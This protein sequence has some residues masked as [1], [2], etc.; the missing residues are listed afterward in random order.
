MAV[1]AILGGPTVLFYHL[2][3]HLLLPS[4]KSPIRL[5]VPCHIQDS[6]AELPFNGN[7][8]TTNAFVPC[9][10]IDA[11]FKGVRILQGYIYSS[12]ET[13]R[14][15]R[16]SL[17]TQGQRIVLRSLRIDYFLNFWG[18][19]TPKSDHGRGSG[20]VIVGGGIVNSAVSSWEDMRN[21][22]F[23]QV[24][25][26]HCIEFGCLLEFLFIFGGRPTNGRNWVDGESGDIALFAIG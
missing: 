18:D 23:T 5:Y 26:L 8:N 22:G 11:L 21:V 25:G 12:I 6:D 7:T 13:I 16:A 3:R 1:D 9:N 17:A 14:M 24:T 20:P 4:G 10:S 15:I 2:V 19:V